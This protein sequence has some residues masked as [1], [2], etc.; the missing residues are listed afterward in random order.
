[1]EDIS[2][3]RYA[4]AIASAPDRPSTRAAL[5]E[6]GA[7]LFARQGVAGVTARALHDAVGAKN[8]SALH[9]HFGGKEG[10]LDE[11]VQQHL[12]AIEG[13]RA[14]LVEA[15][16]AEERTDDLR[17]LLNALALPMAA[18]LETPIGRAHLRLVGQLSHPSLAYERPFQ[19]R[20]APAGTAVS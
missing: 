5:L 11:I 1:M 7:L 20:E 14:P 10:L 12:A 2:R 15:I 18:D 8:E 17:A 16:A 9:Y 6:Q 19:V 3:E 4:P 13:R